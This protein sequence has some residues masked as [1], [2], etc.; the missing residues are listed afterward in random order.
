MINLIFNVHEDYIEIAKVSK[1]FNAVKIKNIVNFT[2]TIDIASNN[3]QLNK[4]FRKNKIKS[5]KVDVILSIDS[6]VTRQIE[7]P[8][9]SE[10]DLKNYITSNIDQYFTVNTGDFY[11]DYKV[12]GIRKEEKKKIFSVLLV[13]VPKEKLDNIKDLLKQ[14]KLSVNKVQIYPECVSSYY[15][16]NKKQS[17]AVLDI[18]NE[19]SSITIIDKGKIFIYSILTLDLNDSEGYNELLDNFTYFLNFYSTRNF[20]NKVDNIYIVGEKGE[21]PFLG[22]I[23]S[24]SIDSNIIYEKKSYYIEIL[25]SVTQVKATHNKAID[26]KE[27]LNDSLK[28]KNQNDGFIM[29]VI[30][31]FFLSVVF[32]GAYYYT[33]I[34]LNSKKNIVSSTLQSELNEYSTVEKNINDL[35][36]EKQSYQ[37]K[38]EIIKEIKN[39][40]FNYLSI[41]DGLKEGLPSNITVKSMDIQRDKTSLTLNINNSTL[42][43]ARAVIAINNTELFEMVEISE[44]KLDDTVNSISLE[45][46]NK[47]PS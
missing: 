44:V 10:K 1:V 34:Y 19:K 35:S 30:A 12:G 43:V 8:A 11:F 6:I 33:E 22:K 4:I 2:P 20:G 24:E 40:E 39:D 7:V 3:A 41:V 31:I 25:G 13:A 42:D 14:N 38:L 9:M 32:M 15:R 21:D 27:T 36:K 17:I 5:K 37:N 28:D 45:L 46:K 29:A 26:F 47:N 16:K 18:S 23:L